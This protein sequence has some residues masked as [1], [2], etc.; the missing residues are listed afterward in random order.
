MTENQMQEV[1]IRELLFGM[2]FLSDYEREL[3]E[4]SGEAEFVEMI[5]RI[6]DS[7]P[8]TIEFS[9][10]PFL[11]EFKNFKLATINEAFFNDRVKYRFPAYCDI[12]DSV[13]NRGKTALSATISIYYAVRYMMIGKGAFTASG[14]ETLN[15]TVSDYD[16]RQKWPPKYRCDDGHYVRSKN[17]QLVDNWLYNHN[18]CH[19]YEPLVVDKKTKR[20]YI[21]DF[22]LPQ[23]KMYIE[24][25]GYENP[26][27]LQRK[28]RK[29]ATYRASGLALL[30]MTDREVAIL[31]DFMLRNIL[32][33]I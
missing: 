8:D 12:V 4:L 10:D 19:A 17:E 9:L 11:P 5:G 16:F 2:T 29:I 30:Q 18:I 27:Y 13:T 32:A 14:G 21:S 25:W 20:E 22:Y 15:E 1:C 23:L 7:V 31:D 3:T 28:E 26:E 24:V 33:K 6:S